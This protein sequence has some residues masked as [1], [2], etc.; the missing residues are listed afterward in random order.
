MSTH[1]TVREL[2]LVL[3]AQWRA[4]TQ[5]IERLPGNHINP[6]F[7][8]IFLT[9]VLAATCLYKR[10]QISLVQKLKL[11]QDAEKFGLEVYEPRD[12]DEGVT[13]DETE[14]NEKVRIRMTLQGLVEEFG[15]RWDDM[16][17][18]KARELA[19]EA[20]TVIFGTAIPEYREQAFVEDKKTVLVDLLL[21]ADE[22]FRAQDEQLQS[23]VLEETG[24]SAASKRQ[25][26]ESF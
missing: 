25:V 24:L 3:N 1:H 21:R 10:E 20:V 18:D 19:Q 7:V 9:S 5:H 23:L 22:E 11:V 17:G 26:S 12:P 16:Q 2:P 13:E 14:E 8:K 6:A 4:L 15:A